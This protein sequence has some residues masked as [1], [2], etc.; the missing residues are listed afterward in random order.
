MSFAKGYL[1]PDGS[2]M[3]PSGA[4]MANYPPPTRSQ[5]SLMKYPDVVNLFHELGHAVH[6]ML[7]RCMY[8]RFHGSQVARDFVEVPSRLVEHFFWDPNVI[9]AVSCHYEKPELD[10]RLP[11]DLIQKTIATRFDFVTSNKLYEM[12]FSVFDNLVHTSWEATDD[13]QTELS[14]L[15]N[16]IRR[17]YGLRHSLEDLGH[18]YDKVHGQ[19]HFRHLTGYASSYY[20]Y[21]A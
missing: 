16:K 9:R 15:F 6:N 19:T 1:K 18:G 2:R 5:P 10:L 21:L 8:S 3:Y 12:V 4:L 20:A 14:V 11:E 17:E 13:G 7:G